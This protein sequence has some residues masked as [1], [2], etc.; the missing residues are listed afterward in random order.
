M[1]IDAIYLREIQMPLVKPFQ[2]SFGTT[3]ARRI[4]LVEIRTEG[5]TGWGECVAGEHPYFS[6][7]CI[8]TAWPIMLHELAP[9]LASADPEHGGKCSEIF[10]LVRGNRMA[11]AALENAV[12]DAEAQM[13]RVPLADLI[14]GSREV[15][16]CGVSI[17]IQPT[18]EQLLAEIETELA[19]GYQRIKLKCKPG[20]DVKVLE[21][22]R[23]RWPDILLSCDANSAYRLRDADH[24]VTFDQFNLLMIEQPLWADDFYY[25][26]MLQKQLETSICLDESI[27]NRR[28]AL[29]AIEM[30]SCRIIN[31]KNGR[32]GGFSEAIAV[33]NAAHERGIPVWCGGMLETGIGRSHN[34]ALS[35][36]E[37]FTLPGDVS[38]SRRYWKE[39]IIEPEVEVSPLGEITVPNTPGRGFEVRT[40]LI[41]KLTVRKEE[42][43]S[44][45]LAIA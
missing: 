25:H 13:R 11:K 16:P 36:L 4:L 3:T 21:A 41:E 30:E 5:F 8:D 31:I 28:D 12:W 43:R 42:I 26:S 15:I 10:R 20:W 37:N 24:L 45:S 19:A 18:L 17:G 34:I 23:N 40:D 27:R 39:D 14:G 1:K 38:A 44:R 29:A 22:V 6:E 2:T 33:H 9:A 35:S 7:E 32:V